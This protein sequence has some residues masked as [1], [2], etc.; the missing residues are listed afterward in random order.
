MYEEGSEGNCRTVL[1]L[2]ARDVVCASMVAN[3]STNSSMID[4]GAA[5]ISVVKPAAPDRGLSMRTGT[6]GMA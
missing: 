3:W 4:F 1:L 2:D 5:D 6:N